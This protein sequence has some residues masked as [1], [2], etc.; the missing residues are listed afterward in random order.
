MIMNQTFQIRLA[1]PAD[2]DSVFELLTASFGDKISRPTWDWLST[3]TGVGQNRTYI[4]VDLQDGRLFGSYS[5]LPLQI[6]LEGRIEAGALCNNVNIHPDYR[7]ARQLKRFPDF[8]DGSLFVA[9]ARHSLQAEGELGTALSIGVPNKPSLPG[10]LKAGWQVVGHIEFLELAPPRA[11]DKPC[12]IASAPGP[13][14]EELLEK[15]SRE[16]RFM[17][18]KSNRYLNWRM[19]RQPPAEYTVLHDCK[20]G[21]S[22]QLIMKIYPDPTENRI[23]AHIVD[24]LSDDIEV[25]RRLLQHAES[26]AAERGCALIDVWAVDHWPYRDTLSNY[27]FSPRTDRRPLIIFHHR[28]E[29]EMPAERWHIT[30]FDNDVY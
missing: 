29:I 27:G 19:R 30:L 25:I 26:I 23:K 9:L 21:R 7:G 8:R 13:E 16:F 10:H 5:M 22:G 11:R 28:K 6:R 2:A 15:A 14:Y 18:W 4:G 20:N 3:D 12:A 24:L 1:T 17:V